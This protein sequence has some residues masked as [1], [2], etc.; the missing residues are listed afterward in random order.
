MVKGSNQIFVSHSSKDTKLIDLITL[1]FKGR[2]IIPFFARREM[3]GE[4]PV[5]KIINAIDSSM[6]L[7][8]L[9][10]SNVVYDKYTR[11]WVV[12]EI[13]VA[14]AKDIP[15]FCWM[16]HDVAKNKAFPKLIENITD[17]DTFNPLRDEEY[18]RVVG[19][20][21]DKA[22]ELKG[23]PRKGLGLTEKEL[24]EGLVRLEEARKIGVEFVVKE[25]GDLAKVIGVTSVMPKNDG[26]IIKGE[27]F[28]GDL[29][30]RTK[31]FVGIKGREVV[32]YTFER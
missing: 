27:A 28:P 16:D 11:D 12:F 20:M 3:V 7:F 1:G 5:E 24:E 17:Y 4:N 18:T 8:A 19:L 10:T 6:A 23:K 25:L 32:S 29:L 30:G 22:Y 21:V 15:I 14:K 9:I 31:W 26:W 2:D 13:G